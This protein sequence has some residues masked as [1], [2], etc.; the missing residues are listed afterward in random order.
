M[1]NIFNLNQVV[2]KNKYNKGVAA[3]VRYDVVDLGKPGPDDWF[4]L[5]KMGDGRLEDYPQMLITLQK[6]A[7][8]KDHPYLIG[9]DEDFK[10]SCSEKLSRCRDVHL[11]YGI[12]LAKRPFIWP[13]VVVEDLTVGI[14]WHI[15]G[16]EIARAAFDRWTKIRSDKANNR[17]LHID[18]DD[19]GS[20]PKERVF[21]EPPIDYETALNKAFKERFINSPDHPVYRNAGSIVDTNFAKQ[22]AKGVI[23]S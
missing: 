17:Y 9:G 8:G 18:L 7:E 19:Q 21:T 1:S 14:G 2:S 16:Y 15:T 10:A 3:T 4:K 6:D 20:V 12:T 13:L 5:Y 11:V 22:V 23:K